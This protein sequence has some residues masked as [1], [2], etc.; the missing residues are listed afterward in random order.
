MQYRWDFDG[1][2]LWDTEY[3][4]VNAIAYKYKLSGRFNAR[5]EVKDIDGLTAIATD[6]VEVYG[7]NYDI[8]TLVDNRDGNRF[9]IVKIGGR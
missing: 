6:S 8:D 9:R 2:G 7:R 1:D 3:S 5:V 4:K